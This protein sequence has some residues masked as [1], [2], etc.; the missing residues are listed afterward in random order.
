MN[1][2]FKQLSKVIILVLSLFLFTNNSKIFSQNLSFDELLNLQEYPQKKIDKFLKSKAWL[3]EPKHDNIWLYGKSLVAD[4]SEAMFVLRNVNCNMNILYYIMSDSLN[5]NDLKEKSLKASEK[6]K[7]INYPT[8]R[9]NDYTLKD[10][11]LRFYESH[12]AGQLAFYAVW[13][14]SK[15]DAWYFGELN[16]F[17]FPTSNKNNKDSINKIF[18][19]NPEFP[20]G[21]EE[22]VKYIRNNLIYPLAARESGIQGTVYITF[23]IE[24]DGSISDIKILRGI[25]GGCDEEVIRLVKNM[26]TW[27]P[28]TQDNKPVIVRFNMP[29]NFTLSNK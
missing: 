2:D 13:V 8:I 18:E 11:H 19:I 5:Y 12:E 17:C 29:V 23:V 9:I 25:G 22:R 26:P 27:M 3:Q 21:E 7:S 6:S 1:I 24:K 4:S 16:K 28:G 10:L 20:G 14:F 15:T